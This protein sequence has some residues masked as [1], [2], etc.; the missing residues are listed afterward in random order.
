M[1]NK[2][3]KIIV[4]EE[5]GAVVGEFIL[6]QGEHLIGRT[7][8]CSIKLKSD[9]VSREHARLI[10]GADTL[11]IEDLD[12]SWGTFLDD[13]QIKGRT[14]IQP[15]QK[16][17]I[18]DLNF[19]IERQSSGGVSEDFQTEEE[20][21]EAKEVGSDA[22]EP[23]KELELDPFAKTAKTSTRKNNEKLIKNIGITVVGFLVLGFL[24]WSFVFRSTETEDSRIIKIVIR[25]SINKP[26]GKLSQDDYDKVKELDLSSKELS[27]IT[28][29]GRL[30][31]LEALNLGGNK[32]N[33][34]NPIS[35]LTTLIKLDLAGNNITE[36]V[37]ISSLVSL[38]ELS[39]GGNK[40]SDL[41]PLS[42]I[43]A[44]RLLDA[45][46]NQIEN[47]QPLSSLSSLEIINLAENNVISLNSLKE[48]KALKMLIASGNASIK[49]SEFADL[50][51]N[52][53]EC[54]MVR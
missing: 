48:L 31:N 43:K 5:D 26:D 47:L 20:A 30:S 21:A 14:P 27:D 4:T 39:L 3:T 51:T 12:S 41:S 38:Q 33:N 9:H 52:L 2:T 18:S 15:T 40:I 28:I 1:S 49:D 53:P 19:D 46:S 44:L 54:E 22:A 7:A 24:L 10:I 23:D 45:G 34:L 37:P 8:D 35:S 25:K 42:N 16:L 50:A 36:L 29:L 13:V 32:V 17:R 6:Q 11:E